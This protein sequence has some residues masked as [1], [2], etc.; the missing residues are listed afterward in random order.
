M[1]YCT[2]RFSTATAVRGARVVRYGRTCISAKLFEAHSSDSDQCS[3]NISIVTVIDRRE[4]LKYRESSD[5]NL[6]EVLDTVHNSK[7]KSTYLGRV[8]L[9]VMLSHTQE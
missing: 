6:G 5:L 8:T 9:I 7:Q 1:V 2:A 3:I 4:H